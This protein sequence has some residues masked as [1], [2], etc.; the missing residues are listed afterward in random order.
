[1]DICFLIVLDHRSQ[2]S[3]F[4]L[5]QFLMRTLSLACKYL[6]LVLITAFLSACRKG[7][8][9]MKIKIEVPEREREGGGRRA[10]KRGSYGSDP[11]FM[12][13]FN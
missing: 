5:I 1:M 11:T 7:E 2:R 6:A 8:M 13:S 10:R 3:R 4:Q 9:E 12:I